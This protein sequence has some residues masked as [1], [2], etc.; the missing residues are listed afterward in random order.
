MEGQ[1]TRRALLRATGGTLAVGLGSGIVTGG[2]PAR[3]GFVQVNVG[4]SDVRGRAAARGAARSVDREF[5]FDALT[6][7]VP[8]QAVAGLSKNPHVRYVEENGVW[9]AIP[10][11]PGAAKPPGGCEPWPECK[12][13]DDGSDGGGGDPPSQTLPWGIDRVD[14]EVAHANGD[15]GAGSHV[16]I[17]DSGIDANHPDLPN[18]GAGR[19]FVNCRGGDCLTSWDDDNDH[20]THCAGIAAAADNTEGVVGVAPG[21]TLHAVKVLDKRGSG[22]WSDVAA[23]IQYVA[24]QGW[25]VGSLSLG[26]SFDSQLVRDAVTYA[27]NAG[28]LLVAAAGNDGPCSGC[29][30]YP[31]AYD[32]VMAVGS[33]TQTDTLSYFSSTGSE[34]EI[35]APGS[36][37][38]STVPGGSY[39][40][41][42]GTSMAC[43]HVSGAGAQLMA[44]GLS[45]EQARAALTS[46]AE[47]IGLAGSEGGAGL[48]DV[49]AAL[50]LDS[51]NN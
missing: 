39:D 14:A 17:I 2:A 41:F 28:V 38:Y 35:A 50:G 45:A 27:V 19:A 33:T 13:G 40:T 36:A 43:P 44:G 10:N 16:A 11:R 15:T 31:A 48:L 34:V 18:V 7:T 24:D 22:S 26:G 46:T 32:G 21:A 20:G 49:A 51:S 29:V 4:Y 5:A 25:D 9:H 47:D 8:Q 1:V 12:D 23:G 37:I 6:L 42:S 30:G 3:D